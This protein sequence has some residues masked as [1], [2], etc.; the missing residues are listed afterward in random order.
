[1][2]QKIR[3]KKYTSSGFVPARLKKFG[4]GTD[5]EMNIDGLKAEYLFKNSLED[6]SGNEYHLT[7]I[8]NVMFKKGL[9][10]YCLYYETQQVGAIVHSSELTSI[11]IGRKPYTVSFWI[12]PT[13]FS[14]ENAEI[15]KVSNA[16]GEAS[17]ISIF[18]LS[19]GIIQFRRQLLWSYSDLYSTEPLKLNKWQHFLC[20][21][22][23]TT[24]KIYINNKLC[25]ELESTL[26]VTQYGILWFG[27][28]AGTYVSSQPG[29][30][31]SLRIFDRILTE[32]EKFELYNEFNLAPIR[33]FKFM[34]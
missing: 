23:G 26:S 5:K 27:L 18:I 19:N 29:Y 28:V 7:P 34:V 14:H 11:F 16:S 17:T 15:I 3:F 20:E 12:M 4:F 31:D 22:N 6:T 9:G 30:Y 8:G 24:M 32:K 2:L 21:Y 33:L 25:G 1:M 13:I 10:G